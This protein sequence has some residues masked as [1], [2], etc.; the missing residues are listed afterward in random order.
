MYLTYLVIYGI[1]SDLG[2]R[3]SEDRSFHSLASA[4]YREQ[5]NQERDTESPSNIS[6]V[7]LLSDEEKTL[8]AVR[9]L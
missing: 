7:F 2:R 9:Q 8:P 3:S 4:Q 6:L 5:G 1:R